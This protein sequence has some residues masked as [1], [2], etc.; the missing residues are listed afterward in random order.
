MELTPPEAAEL[1]VVSF[2]LADGVEVRV[3]PLQYLEKKETA[4]EPH[5]T[6]YAPR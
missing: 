5:K 2:T 3:T 4:G 6:Y 1:P